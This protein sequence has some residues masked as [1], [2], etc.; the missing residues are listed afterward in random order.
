M[1]LVEQPVYLWN[2]LTYSLALT[3]DVSEDC[4]S[5]NGVTC[6]IQQRQEF[7]ALIQNAPKCKSEKIFKSCNQHQGKNHVLIQRYRNKE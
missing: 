6:I 1:N 5:I 2:W 4:S 7:D 3:T